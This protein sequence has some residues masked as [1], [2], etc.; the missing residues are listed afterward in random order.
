MSNPRSSDKGAAS[1]LALALALNASIPGASFAQ[2]VRP[3]VLRLGLPASAPLAA[4]A[5]AGAPAVLS[6]SAVSP[7]AS[8]PAAASPAFAAAPAASAAAMSA[9]ARQVG[10]AARAVGSISKADAGSAAGFGA[11]VQALISGETLAAAAAADASSPAPSAQTPDQRVML[12]TLDQVVTLFTEHYGPMEWKQSRYGVDFAAEYRKIRSAVLAQP[13]M[14]QREFQKLLAGL[15]ASTRDYHVSIRF[16]STEKA[17]LP[18][19]IMSSQGRSFVAAIDRE[20]LPEKDFPFQPGDEVLEM[21]GKPVAETAATFTLV[22]NTAE[23]DARLADLS[24]THRSRRSGMDVPQ[25]DVVLKIKK[26]D[27]SV[28]DAKLT[29]SYTPEMVPVDVPV[30]EGGI[31]PK[32]A[33]ADGA[34]PRDPA[35]EAVR[36]AIRKLMRPMAH[37][38]TE[39]MLARKKAEPKASEGFEIGGKNSFVPALGKSTQVIPDRI[40]DKIPFVARIDVD[41]QGRRIGYIRI[42]DYEGD[43]NAVKVFAVLIKHYQEATDALVLDQVNN[44]GGSVFY[45]YSLLSML[46]DKPLQVPQHRLLIDESDAE[47]AATILQQAQDPALRKILAEELSAQ[48]GDPGQSVSPSVDELVGYA[49]FVLAELKAGRR[50]TGPVSVEGLPEIPPAGVRYTKP[51]FTLTNELDFSGADFLPQILQDNKRA[52]LFGV[53]TAGA[54]GMVKSVEF[55]NQSGV[56]HVSYTWSIAQ[57]PGGNPVENL[58]VSPD[59]GY[60]P[61]PDD[62]RDGFQGYKKALLAAIAARVPPPAPGAGKNVGPKG[63]SKPSPRKRKP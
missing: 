45:M 58:G 1:A 62:F 54:G 13:K 40:A 14:P 3:G 15:I 56:A 5:R 6:P 42:P 48:A 16:N 35:R 4:A 26:A 21:G 39:E 57:R 24:L 61:T 2:V 44:P 19:T 47:E 32:V 59:V 27:G 49:K 25:G 7:S 18:L 41:A 9:I 17:S 20:A 28:Q 30:R 52:T 10:E 38:E 23:T 37:P 46:T 50:F 34:A 29:W 36:R 12:R 43:A 33:L 53:R 8:L 31:G 63:P 51:I 60:S 55:P 22:P 11:R